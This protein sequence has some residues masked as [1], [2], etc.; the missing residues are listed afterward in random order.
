M[1]WNSRANKENL[2]TSQT[3]LCLLMSERELLWI[4]RAGHIKEQHAPGRFCISVCHNLP[5]C[6]WKLNLPLYNFFFYHFLKNVPIGL[7][8]FM[9]C[10]AS[11]ISTLS[12]IRLKPQVFLD[13]KAWGLD[14]N[15]ERWERGCYLKY[16]EGKMVCASDELISKAYSYKIDSS[17]CV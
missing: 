4:V 7:A 10:L 13:L 12:M 16:L 6:S 3:T 8:S 11:E 2:P 15:G 1:N 9:I 5:E 14:T 17:P